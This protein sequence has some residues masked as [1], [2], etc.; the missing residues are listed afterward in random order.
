MFFRLFLGVLLLATTASAQLRGSRFDR[1][2]S[3]AVT[4]AVSPDGLLVAV[5]RS[6]GGAA[7]RYGRVDLW[8][9][10]TGELQR[11]I[12]GFDGP[13]W[14]MTFSKDGRSLLTVSTEY[15]EAK[16]QASIKDRNEKVYA[17]LK[18][19]DVESGEFINK[20]SLGEEGVTSL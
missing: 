20:L 4:V 8:D 19:W 17:E 18:W 14:S 3:R 13:I 15:R 6:S 12:T 1:H 10:K 11:T 5:A 16:I 7:K 9:S 2:E